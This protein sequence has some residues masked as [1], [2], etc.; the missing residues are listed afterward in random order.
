[1]L[2][3]NGINRIENISCTIDKNSDILYMSN[4]KIS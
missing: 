4:Y 2:D 1:M 3:T